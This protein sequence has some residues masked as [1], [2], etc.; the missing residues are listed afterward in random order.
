MLPRVVVI[1]TVACTAA[2]QTSPAQKNSNSNDERRCL[3]VVA[4]ECGCT[5][6][7]GIG[8][9]RGGDDRWTVHHPFW[10]SAALDARVDAWC[11]DGACTPAFLAAIVCDGIC[12]PKAGDPTCRFD[13]QGACVGADPR[14]ER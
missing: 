9:R 14:T 12:A 10:G 7:C 8:V 13:A 2:T 4:K 1:L 6:S 11:V 3:P 5:Y